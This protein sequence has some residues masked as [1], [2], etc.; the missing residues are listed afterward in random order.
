[1]YLGKNF[2]KLR[3]SRGL[4]QEA[5]A[6]KSSLDIRTCQR[7]EAGKSV[8][9]STV[10]RLADA[11]KLDTTELLGNSDPARNEQTEI[12]E[13]LAEWLR[14]G[15]DGSISGVPAHPELF[16]R[17]TGQ[18]TG[19][20]ELLSLKPGSPHYDDHIAQDLLED[21]AWREFKTFARVVIGLLIEAEEQ[22]GRERVSSVILAE[23]EE[24]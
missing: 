6:E 23:S 18:W 24:D 8:S 22:V 4:T 16:Y 15:N 13:V 7:A 14:H 20:N 9:P 12:D 1:M 21:K 10:F 17:F 19:W 5:L 3:E 11:L 2:R